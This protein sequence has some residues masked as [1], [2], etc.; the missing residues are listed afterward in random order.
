ML[1][2]A[3]THGNEERGKEK[4]TVVSYGILPILLTLFYFRSALHCKGLLPYFSFLLPG[5]SS[6]GK[7]RAVCMLRYFSI[8]FLP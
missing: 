2:G 6:G 3:I 4:W 1:V 8:V 7:V 5:V